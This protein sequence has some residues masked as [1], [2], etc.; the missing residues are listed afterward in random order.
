MEEI[1]TQLSATPLERLENLHKRMFLKAARQLS[2]VSWWRNRH[3]KKQ[4]VEL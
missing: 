1:K 4:L 2:R 3:E